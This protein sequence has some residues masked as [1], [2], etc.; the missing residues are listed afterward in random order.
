[1]TTTLT[2][3]SNDLIEL[4]GD[5]REEFSYSDQPEGDLLGFSDGTLLRI[6]FDDDGIWRINPVRMGPGLTSITQG[7]D[8]DGTDT[9]VL[10]DVTWVLHGTSYAKARA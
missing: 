1:M 5:I 6:R 9:A 4:D 10:T 3:H 2:G 8:D 7:S